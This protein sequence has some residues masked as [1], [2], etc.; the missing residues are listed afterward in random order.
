[1]ITWLEYWLLIG[2]YLWRM[3]NVTV[4]LGPGTRTYKHP[5]DVQLCQN[6]STLTLMLKSLKQSH[7]K[8]QHLR[9][10]L[11]RSQYLLLKKAWSEHSR[12]KLLLMLLFMIVPIPTYL[13]QTQIHRGTESFVRVFDSRKLYLTSPR[14]DRQNFLCTLII[15]TQLNTDHQFKRLGQN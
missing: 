3:L 13:E 12:T 11:S 7:E 9:H 10:S 8:W 2:Q 15:L 14:L 5:Q 4:N 1:M 6:K